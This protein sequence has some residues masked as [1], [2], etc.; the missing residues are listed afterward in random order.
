MVS[1][2]LNS[3]RRQFYPDT[4][5]KQWDD[6]KWQLQNR[7]TK[8]ED[9]KRIFSLDDKTCAAFC[10]PRPFP[11]AVTPY[12]AS[13]LRNSPALQKTMLPSLKEK[14]ISAGE[15]NDPLGEEPCMVAPGVVHRYPDRV[16]FLVTGSCASYCRYCTRSRL[17]GQS[18][19]FVP[20]K[21]DYEK[22]FEYIK[23]HPEIRD[24]LVSGGDPLTL[25]DDVIAYLLKS[26]RSI[27]HV[28]MIRIASK[29]P[30]VLPMRITPQL[31]KMVRKYHPVFFSLH[32][33]HPDE[34]SPETV[35]ACTRIADAGIPAGSQTV[36]LK[37][38][39]DCS[40]TLKKLMHELLKARVRPY[41]L[42][43][44]DPIQGSSHFRV[45]LDKGLKIIDELR[46]RTSGY[47]VPTFAVDI[48][49]GGGK[50]VMT[51]DH[52][53]GRKDDFVLFRN[54]EGKVY[55]YPDPLSS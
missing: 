10:Q 9:F 49:G 47:A 48:P 5:H 22:A 15:T 44:C 27:S 39:N 4:S 17:V 2:I 29:T 51:P 38:V 42:F 25:E 40:E 36:L 46:G 30:A 16:L 1:S 31:M 26:L 12:Y 18:R 53:V 6:W 33:T 14:L 3:F 45:P 21:K 32:F 37:N 52:L 20:G 55:K 43:Q 11:A 54:F 28:E 41:Y 8:I 13:I 23:A 50:I 35:K 19:A 34:M 24:V 7:L